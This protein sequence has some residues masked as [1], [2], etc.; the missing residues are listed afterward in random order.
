MIARLSA[1]LTAVRDDQRAKEY[2]IR[3]LDGELAAIRGD[4]VFRL[5]EALR[6]RF[7]DRR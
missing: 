2:L 4:R 3:Q 5:L 7:G 1:E 6:A